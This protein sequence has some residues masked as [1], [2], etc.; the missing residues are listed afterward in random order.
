MAK[1]QTAKICGKCVHYIQHYGLFNGVY[2]WGYLGHC[3][4]GR[5]KPRRP[6]AKACEQYEQALS[7]KTPAPD[8]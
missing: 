7:E 5:L 8:F 4:Q 6:D 2:R 1:E 3:T